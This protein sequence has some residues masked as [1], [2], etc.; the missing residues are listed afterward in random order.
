M[1]YKLK[2]IFNINTLILIVLELLLVVLLVKAYMINTFFISHE[3]SFLYGFFQI[4]A[5]D[6]LILFIIILSV[7]LSYLN[8]L[9]YFISIFLRLISFIIFTLYLIDLYIITQFANHLVFSDV[10]KYISYTP[11][12]LEQMYTFNIFYFITITIFSVILIY[13][14]LKKP[15]IEEKSFHYISIIILFVLL[16]LYQFSENGRYIH[17]WLYK[18]FIEYNYEIS[19]LSKPYSKKFIENISYKESFECKDN[20]P[21]EKNI[22][23]LM[24][25][26]LS[27]YQSKY[28]SGIKNWTPYIDKIA[29]EN[30]SLTNFHANGFVTE[31]AEI[32]MLTGELPIYSPTAF[33]TGG[34]VSFDGFYNIEKALPKLLKKKGYNS[35]FITSSDLDF[36]HTGAWAKSNG[37]DYIEGSE[38]SDYIGKPRF[39]FKAAADEYLYSRILNRISKQ[40]SKYFI[41]IKTVSSHAPFVNPEDNSPSEEGTIK[42]IDKQ[43]GIFYEKLQKQNFFNNGILIILGDHHPVIPIKDK[44]FKKFG[45]LKSSSITPAILVDGKRKEVIKDNFQ[46]TD[47]Y[48]SLKNYISNTTCTSNWYGDIINLVKAPKYIAHRRGDERGIISIFLENKE[49]NIKLNGDKT[50]AVDTINYDK[51]I[52]DKINSTRILRDN[53]NYKFNN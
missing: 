5:H 52:L 25:E 35:E 53:T 22:I 15:K 14:F 7:Y 26:S 16:F 23:I 30:V 28:F 11:K 38:H 50:S 18:N 31:D 43:I 44:E 6:S 33:S 13:F 37:F 17:S 36:S 1:L 2:K 12:Y 47:I 24:V 4:I 21:K 45:K 40:T 48:N 3:N 20:I 27:S 51:N 34:G 41:F 19:D 8:F 10:I 49:F 32:A 9:N 42:Y 39:H 29:K 46:Q